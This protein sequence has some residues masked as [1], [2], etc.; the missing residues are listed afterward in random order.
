MYI[1][2][3]S[4]FFTNVRFIIKFYFFLTGKDGEEGKH[5]AKPGFHFFGESFDGFD[6][7]SSLG[8][9]GI[10]P[11]VTVDYEIQGK[12]G[13]RSSAGGDGGC[14]GF[15]GLPGDAFVVQLKK[16]TPLS[17]KNQRGRADIFI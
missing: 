11:F 3:G 10:P 5:P 2:N 14:G 15:G 17:I 7:T 6:F 12:T 13:K 9:C 8:V 1:N 16:S 4:R